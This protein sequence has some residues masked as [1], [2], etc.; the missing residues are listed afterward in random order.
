MR[1]KFNQHGQNI[2]IA[3]K[4]EIVFIS[5][6]GFCQEK[7][8]DRCI[9]FFAQKKGDAFLHPLFSNQCI[10]TLLNRDRFLR[11]SARLIRGYGIPDHRNRL[12]RAA[13]RAHAAADALFIVNFRVPFYPIPRNPMP[14]GKFFIGF[15][16]ASTCHKIPPISNRSRWQRPIH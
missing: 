10:V 12:L 15:F 6:A 4:N 7:K 9:H 16:F 5:C 1:V 13:C 8:R 14:F 11:F 2:F 3:M